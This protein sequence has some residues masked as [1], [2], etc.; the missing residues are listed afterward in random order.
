MP[1]PTVAK[2]AAAVPAKPAKYVG[3]L[4]SFRAKKQCYTPDGAIV[5][6]GQVFQTNTEGYIDGSTGTYVCPPYLE[7]VS[8]KKE[9]E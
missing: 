1:E 9:A 2:P 4:Q 5:E 6:P 8:E 7:E 3:H